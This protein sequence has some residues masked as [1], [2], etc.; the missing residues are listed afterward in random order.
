MFLRNLLENRN[1]ILT[2]S[3]VSGLLVPQGSR[4]SMDFVLPCLGL[5]MTLTCMGIPAGLFRH[6]LEILRPVLLGVILTFPVLGGLLF[7]L[8]TLLI[9]DPVM[10]NGLYIIAVSPPGVAIVPFTYFLRGNITLSLAAVVGG[11]LAALVIMPVAGILLFESRLVDP[12][13]LFVIVAE[14]IVIPV[15]LSRIAVK[16]GIAGHLEPVRGSIVN[17]AFFV[18]VY[19]I[20]G[21]NRPVFFEQPLSLVPVGGI[22]VACSFVLAGVMQ[23][24]AR[25]L[26]ADRETET[27]MVLLATVKNYGLAG[28]LAL[29]LFEKE[30]AVPA[31]VAS[32]VLIVFFI[33]LGFKGRSSES[34]DHVL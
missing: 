4:L 24:V 23:R 12:V 9:S 18:I 31:A 33:W 10:K 34:Q 22:M 29:A 13:K 28:G 25:L 21:L 5:M 16:S 15:V 2:L 26:K 8:T 7:L 19:T 27:S 32:V 20:V 1:F 30:A 17:W 3:L 6:P 11:Y 14:L